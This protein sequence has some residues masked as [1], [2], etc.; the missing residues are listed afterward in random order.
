MIKRILKVW[1]DLNQFDALEPDEAR[2]GRVLNILLLGAFSLSTVAFL[3][4][5]TLIMVQSTWTRPGNVL[6]LVGTFSFSIGVLGLLFL[7][8]QKTR[9][10]ALLFLLLLTTVFVFSDVPGELANGRSSFVFFIPIAISSL[11]L[12]PLSSFL[13]AVL[14]G[15]IIITLTFIADST[16]NIGTII[17]FFMLAIISW[18]SSNSLEQAIK[19]LRK[20]NVELDMRVAERTRELSAS[21]EREAMQASQREA[22]LNSIA[23][24]V[25]VFDNAGTAIVA[26]PS[27]SQ[28]MDLPQQEILG[29]NLDVLLNQSGVT[30]GEKLQ[31]NEGL[32]QKKQA[33][34]FRINW[35]AKTMSIHA[36]EVQSAAKISLGTVAVFR[37]ITREVELDK[38]K[39]TFLAIV[40]HEM[41]TP[42]NAILGFAEMIKEA[43]YGPV[44]DKQAKAVSRIMENSRRL[45][46]IVGELLDQAQ[47]QSGRMKISLEPCKPDE[48][49]KSIQD[50]MAKSA[51]DKGINLNTL[52]DPMLPS[53]L[54]GDSQRLQQI[55]INLTN[56]AIKF[57]SAGAS[58]QLSI[59]RSGNEHWKIQ[60]SD[61]GEGIPRESLE[62]V[63]DTFRQVESAT[64]RKHGGVGLGLAIV[65]QLVELMNGEIA[66]ESQVQV[67]ST[68]TIT[69]PLIE[70]QEKLA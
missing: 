45:L 28:L 56:N 21:L 63:F 33:A 24:G 57:S 5:L 22:I 54:L 39:D 19:D 44:S 48:L 38:M 35:G 40:S 20:I 55:M 70:I 64:T 52:L 42:L 62:Y 50:T 47:I 34:A 2:R 49:L 10:T 7:N 41:R 27:L 14:N 37:D 29:Q 30:S 3:G 67:G 1:N 31:V 8:R 43:V 65:K 60:V 36:A 11:L 9:L 59:L 13:F 15:I 46:L 69:L 16:L 25:V 68:F 26:N 18:L 32:K 23:D 58:V 4:A 6:L 61:T 53:T 66:V 51:T 12:A 17:G